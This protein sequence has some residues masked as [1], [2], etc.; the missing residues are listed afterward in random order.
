MLHQGWPALS[1][2]I[3]LPRGNIGLQPGY[4]A[5]QVSQKLLLRRAK[6]PSKGSGEKG[7]QLWPHQSSAPTV[8]GKLVKK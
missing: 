1:S 6:A 2:V 4:N 8:T 7:L 5:F 3:H